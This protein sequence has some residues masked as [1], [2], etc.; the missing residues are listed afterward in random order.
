MNVP[1]YSAKFNYLLTTIPG[2]SLRDGTKSANANAYPLIKNLAK[3]Q[4]NAA[5]GQPNS[6]V[7]LTEIT[8]VLVQANN[9]ALEDLTVI[10]V[11]G[12]VLGNKAAALTAVLRQGSRP[13]V[14]TALGKV[15]GNK[16]A[17]LTAAPHQALGKTGQRHQ[18]AKHVHR[19]GQLL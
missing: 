7:G 5:Q 15:P 16:A 18:V 17:A 1:R 9:Q 4:A 10:T 2:Q 12:R 13:A 19:A 8:V 3:T 14:T 11:A 6:L